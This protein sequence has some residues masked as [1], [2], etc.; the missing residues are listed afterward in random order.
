M[1]HTTTT[2][3][4]S[5]VAIASRALELP[6]AAK[7]GDGPDNNRAWSLCITSRSHISNIRRSTMCSPHGRMHRLIPTPFESL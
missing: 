3:L 1:W 2:Q 5:G 6:E 7:A 4:R